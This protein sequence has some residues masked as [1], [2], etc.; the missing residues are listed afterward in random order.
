[1]IK[2]HEI[3]LSTSIY[4]TLLNTNSAIIQD[5]EKKITENDYV[6]FK[7][8]EIVDEK[9]QETGLYKFVKITK[10]I[11]NHAGL[12]EGYIMITYDEVN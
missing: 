7:Q 3:N 4:N 9:E 10:S 6:L 8:V 11:S 5:D 2:T 1:M 12:K